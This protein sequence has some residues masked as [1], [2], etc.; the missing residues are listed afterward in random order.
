MAQ[1]AQHTLLQAGN[2][3]T[4]ELFTS[5]GEIISIAGPSITHE[6]LDITNL[7]DTYRAFIANGVPDAGEIGIEVQ[8]DTDEATQLAMIVSARDGT[9]KNYQICWSNLDVTAKAFIAADVNVGADTITEAA[10]LLTTGQ[11][12]RFTTDDTLPDPLVAGVTYYVIWSD[13]NTIQVAT[14]NALA[15]AGTEIN[16]IDAGVGNHNI[17]LGDRYDFTASISGASPGGSTGDKLTGTITFKV[18]GA[19]SA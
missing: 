16:L 13:A 12:I 17:T 18:S 5:V 19:I 3:A 4:P 10:H 7:G 2:A 11:P 1:H 15:V 14:T 9:Q 6:A 8:W